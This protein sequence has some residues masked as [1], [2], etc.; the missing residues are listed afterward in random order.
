MMEL[1]GW[2]VLAS[3]SSRQTL[4]ATAS[5]AVKD[6][7][8]DAGG[9]SLT[10]D[11]RFD[12]NAFDPVSLG[13][14]LDKRLRVALVLA[15]GP[16][17]ATVALAAH[18][19]GMVSIGWA[20]LAFDTLPGA[21]QHVESSYPQL[22]TVLTALSGWMYIEPYKPAPTSFF[23]SVRERSQTDFGQLLEPNA[24]VSAYAAN[25]YDAIF[26]FA[27]GLERH[28]PVDHYPLPLVDHCDRSLR[29]LVAGHS[30]RACLRAM[31]KLL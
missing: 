13:A 8:Q 29:F 7:L 20:W 5:T 26:L 17:L 23:E 16:D 12:A 10:V 1:C 15:Y 24:T 28:S 30:R 14:M 21:E 22:D 27:H 3:F 18:N 25:L 31:G 11:V 2:A 19:R 6:E 4:F 9:M